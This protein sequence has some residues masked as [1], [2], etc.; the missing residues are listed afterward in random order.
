MPSGH[1]SV[2]TLWPIDYFRTF[3]IYCRKIRKGS[4]PET[5]GPMQDGIMAPKAG[6]PL[7]QSGK[8]NRPRFPRRKYNGA[9]NLRQGSRLCC[10]GWC[11]WAFVISP[12]VLLALL[13]GILIG[14]ELSQ[15]PPGEGMDLVVTATG[16]RLLGVHGGSGSVGGLVDWDECVPVGLV[17]VLLYLDSW[18]NVDNL[19]LF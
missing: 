11:F 12:L 15:V 7:Y 14:V 3:P 6:L 4:A 8:K 17:S 16:W 10:A 19:I 9:K 13:M 2:H 1:F 5:T 18:S